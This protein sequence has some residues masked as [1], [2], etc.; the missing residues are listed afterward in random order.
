MT[1]YSFAFGLL[2]TLSLPSFACGDVEF[3]PL[4]SL[5]ESRAGV[6]DSTAEDDGGVGTHTSR[7]ADEKGAALAIAEYLPAPGKGWGSGVGVKVNT[8]FTLNQIA[9]VSVYAKAQRSSSFVVTHPQILVFDYEVHTR[10]FE[11]LGAEAG[12]GISGPNG[13]Y[14]GVNRST[15]YHFNHDDANRGVTII[16][17]GEYRLSGAATSSFASNGYSSLASHMALASITAS[18]ELYPIRERIDVGDFQSD[19]YVD[20]SDFLAWQ[21]QAGQS[22][23]VEDSADENGDGVVDGVDLEQWAEVFGRLL[24]TPEILAAAYPNGATPIPEPASVSLA[25]IA[26]ATLARSAQRANRRKVT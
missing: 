14:L 21:R 24:P 12:A 20:G 3:L 26:F 25:I 5:V 8:A 19:G 10:T 7:V 6:D 15:Q 1:R 18:F 17:P 11:G 13:F 2:V 9:F 23:G 22:P 4:V 16:G